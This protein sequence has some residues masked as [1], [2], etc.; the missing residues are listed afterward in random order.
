MLCFFHSTGERPYGCK[1]CFKAF[2]DYA[3]IRKHLMMTHKMDKES[4]KLHVHR[5][6]RDFPDHYVPGGPGYQPRE[7]SEHIRER[8]QAVVLPPKV[9]GGQTVISNVKQDILEHTHQSPSS[10]PSTGHLENSEI[11]DTYTSQKTTQ[12]QHV[13]ETLELPEVHEHVTNLAPLDHSKVGA[14]LSDD[15]NSEKPGKILTSPTDPSS[16]S[17]SMINT[18]AYHGYLPVNSVAMETMPYSNIEYQNITEEMLME[19][20]F[21]SQS[22]QSEKSLEDE[23]K[24]ADKS[25]ATLQ[26]GQGQG[27]IDQQQVYSLTPNVAIVTTA[28]ESVSGYTTNINTA[29][30]LPN[31]TDTFYSSSMYSQYQQ[32][33]PDQQL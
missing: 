27:Q 13:N 6:A 16:V 32:G 30:T 19:T 24:Y 29:W 23:S 28:S 25:D 20:L 31:Y 7:T 11:A 8:N 2:T 5:E 18:T 26:T 17:D 12:S 33:S 22:R 3:V 14:N 10:G 21:K 1:V 9:S 4:W 15:N